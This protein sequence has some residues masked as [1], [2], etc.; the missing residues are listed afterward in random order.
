MRELTPQEADHFVGWL[1]SAPESMH[2]EFKRVSGKMV[3]KAL[4]S[5]CAMANTQGGQLILG[6]DDPSKEKGKARLFGIGENPEAVDE[7]LRPLRA[8]ILLFADEHGLRQAHACW[9]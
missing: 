6:V 3:G 2:L 7:L 4:E 8:A 5:I 1:L 9:P